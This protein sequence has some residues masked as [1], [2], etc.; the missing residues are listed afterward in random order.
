MRVLVTGGSSG[1]GRATAIMLGQA[2]HEV[3]VAGRCPERTQDAAR[4]AGGQAVT[5]DLADFDAAERMVADLGPLDGLVHCAGISKVLPLRM[6]TAELCDRI[7][8]TNWA[9]AVA[10][11]KGFRR[12]KSLTVTDR[13]I[14]LVSSQAATGL[15][16]SGIYG[17]SKAAVATLARSL[18]GELA[19]ERIRVNCVTPGWV[20][21]PLTDSAASILNP[22]QL[23]SISAGSA[24]GVGEPGDVA[25]AILYLLTSR[26]TTGTNL[27][28]DGGWRLS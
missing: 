9:S 1:I 20:R 27:V 14:V 5:C 11:C 24:L 26:W 19:R 10:V 4:E 7:M 6:V 13:S 25:A 28:I 23:G 16:G 15:P 3:V 17:S 12:A 22:K 2:G 8:R 21:T 18:A